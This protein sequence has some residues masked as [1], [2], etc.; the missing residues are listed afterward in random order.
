MTYYYR[1]LH[2]NNITLTKDDCAI[3]TMEAIMKQNL[4]KYA[5]VKKL[6][7]LKEKIHTKFL[8]HKFRENTKQN[9]Q[10]R[11]NVAFCFDRN[12]LKPAA[13]AITSLVVNAHK[14]CYNIYCVITQDV[15]LLD[16]NYINSIVRRFSP[17]SNVHFIEEEG[18]FD[19]SKTTDRS[20]KAIYFRMLLPELLPDIDK[21]IYLDIDLIVCEP[22]LNLYNTDIGDNLLAGV[23]NHFNSRIRWLVLEHNFLYKELKLNRKEYINSGVLI[24]NLQK[25]REINLTKLWIDLSQK[26]LFWAVDQDILNCICEGKKFL[27]PLKYNYNPLC[28]TDFEILASEKMIRQDDMEDAKN[29]AAIIHFFGKKKPWKTDCPASEIWWKYAKMLNYSKNDFIKQ[30]K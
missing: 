5:D 26:Y 28:I 23:L 22:L 20:S 21:I 9:S 7:K 25:L 13:V 18:S 8:V 16:K 17:A 19:L 11:V 2:G 24:M 3:E 12:F 14:C 4:L 15:D 10:R 27:L 29:A 1:R 30:E 6:D